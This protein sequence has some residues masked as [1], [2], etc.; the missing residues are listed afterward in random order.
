MNQSHFDTLG[1]SCDINRAIT[2][3][4]YISFHMINVDALSVVR[5]VLLTVLPDVKYFGLLA[6]SLGLVFYPLGLFVV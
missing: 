5:L 2:G 1:I 6:R 4:H 3:H